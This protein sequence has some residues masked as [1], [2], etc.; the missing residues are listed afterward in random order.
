MSFRAWSPGEGRPEGCG[1]WLIR[2]GR[3]GKER[4]CRGSPGGRGRA[5]SLPQTGGRRSPALQP[6]GFQGH[7]TETGATAAEVEH[8]EAE[9]E[10]GRKCPRIHLSLP[11]CHC[12]SH[13]K[14]EATPQWTCPTPQGAPAEARGEQSR[15]CDRR[16]SP[17]PLVSSSWCC[18]GHG[19]R[20]GLPGHCVQTP[21][22]LVGQSVKWY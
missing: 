3:V 4:T 20:S 6:A 22:A 7:L 10:K 8:E 12:N 16:P 14:R 17:W 19:S 18:R 1:A 5:G 15:L 2:L 11:H 13:R 9:T 21:Y